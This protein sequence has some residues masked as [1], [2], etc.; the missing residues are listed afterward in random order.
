MHARLEER[1]REIAAARRRSMLATLDRLAADLER[2]G[3]QL[4]IDALRSAAKAYRDARAALDAKDAAEEELA[5]LYNA[6][7]T[8]SAE[9][10]ALMNKVGAVFSVEVRGEDEA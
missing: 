6:L 1:R 5:Q 10:G 4:G 7:R 3:A 9:I 2:L 8:C